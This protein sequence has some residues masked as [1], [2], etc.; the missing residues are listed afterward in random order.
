MAEPP[1][2]RLTMARLGLLETTAVA[3]GTAAMEAATVAH[4]PRRLEAHAMAG[5]AALHPVR[6][7]LQ[8]LRPACPCVQSG[9]RLL[10]HRSIPS[11][12]GMVSRSFLRHR[13]P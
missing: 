8:G 1:I 5:R 6:D 10:R 3:A 2:T 7:C 13:L 9:L 4:R 11:I 12:S